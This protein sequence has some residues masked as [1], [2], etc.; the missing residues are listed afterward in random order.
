MK[1]A[2]EILSEHGLCLPSDAPGRYYTTCPQCSAKRSKEH[3]SNKVLGI[4]IDDKGVQWGCNHC[5]WTGGSYYDARPNGQANG[6]A[7]SNIVATYDYPDATGVVRFQKVR[8]PPG[9]EPRFWLRRP[10]SNGGWITGTKGVDTSLLYRL[11][12]VI[13]A[14][15]LGHMIAVPEGEKDCD[16]LWRIGIPATCNAHGAADATKKQKPKWTAAHSE[17]LRGAD[18][19]ILNDND[20][21][22]REH[23]DAAA[24][25][26]LG[27]A[28]RVRRLDVAKHWPNMPEKADVSDWLAA[29][30][31]REEL[32]ALIATAPEFANQAS[33]ELESCVAASLDM[34]GIEWF[35]PGRFARGKLALLAGLPDKGKGQVCAYLAAAATASIALP[36]SEGIAPQGNVIW[37]NAE[38]GMRDT[39]VPRLV[40]AG[41]NLSRVH[42]ITAT[43]DQGRR[44]PFSLLT[45]LPLL[46]MKI[47][48]IGNVVLVI[49]DPISAYLGVG[50]LDGRS[51]SD[52]RG[53]L[54]PLKDLAEATGVLV[55]GI[56]HFNK[57]N[58]VTSA[59]LR[60]ADSIAFTATARHV[61]AIIDD[62]EDDKLRLFVKVKNNLA[63]LDQK[64]LRYGFGFA[65]C[66]GR[67]PVRNVDIGAPYIEWA[68]EGVDLSANDA[69]QALASSSTAFAKREAK[70]FLL[71]RLG[72][73]PVAAK[74]LIEEA[75]QAGISQR[76]LY[77][78]KRDLRIAS[79]K[80]EHGWLWLPPAKAAGQDC[81][82]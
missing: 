30:H 34:Q 76:T 24:R 22:G 60:I 25:L 28:A 48:Q 82:A 37:F 72:E 77:A 14:I 33:D 80:G 39:I 50:K 17:Q 38:D 71:D 2:A 56:M 3:R 13:E 61:Y 63:P 55:L 78:A 81:N 11:P 20:L 31:T 44:R 43:R 54:T 62:S 67:D 1:T 32:D 4:T 70:D 66:V 6:H 79:K 15:A 65:H 27:V 12:E 59:L 7:G 47:E 74:E 45:D 9:R 41:A 75:A 5:A 18:L 29:G 21:S 52:V 53:M 58:D 8:N 42:F 26:S 69:M 64:A 57:K 46:R 36:C 35:W 51:Q 40:A 23:A 68:S 10:D 16:N 73:N 49:I 19:V